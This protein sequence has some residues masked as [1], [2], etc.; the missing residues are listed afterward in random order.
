MVW[1]ILLYHGKSWDATYGFLFDEKYDTLYS[2]L[3]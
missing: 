2:G 3:L 1:M